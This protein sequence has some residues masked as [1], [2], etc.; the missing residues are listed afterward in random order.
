MYIINE[1]DAIALLPGWQASKGANAEYWTAQF[2]DL[3]IWELSHANQEATE[4]AA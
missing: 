3:N 4:Q 2:L 1:A